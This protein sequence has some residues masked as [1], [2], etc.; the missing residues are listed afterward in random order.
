MAG[1]GH[2]I[3][4]VTFKQMLACILLQV[5]LNLQAARMRLIQ[6]RVLQQGQDGV[7]WRHFTQLPAN[8][9]HHEPIVF[10]GIKH[11]QAAIVSNT[12]FSIGIRHQ[13][14]A[15]YISNPSQTPLSLWIKNES[16]PDGYC[17]AFTLN[18]LH[19]WSQEGR[20]QEWVDLGSTPMSEQWA[21]TRY[22]A[23]PTWLCIL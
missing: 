21:V 12:V 9:K 6:C 22:S 8:S 16:K 19:S 3:P 2:T 17:E 23:G 15:E 13:P 18:F 7:Q 14:T 5:D 20:R 4:M 1:L 11:I 10:D